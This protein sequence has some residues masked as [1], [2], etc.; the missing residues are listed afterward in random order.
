M[1]I[2]DR[3]IATGVSGN[4]QI[5]CHEAFKI[6]VDSMKKINNENFKDLKLRRKDKCLSLL[7]TVNSKIKIDDTIVPVDPLLLFQ[8]ISVMKK[9]TR[10]VGRIY[11][12]RTSSISFVTV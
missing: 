1:C 4:S 5:N 11:E 10:R 3:S 9:I 8:R 7:A 2:R 12:V 6:G